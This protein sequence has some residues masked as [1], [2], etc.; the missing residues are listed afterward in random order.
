MDTEFRI[1]A[2]RLG[3]RSGVR[4]GIGPS[5]TV[6]RRCGHRRGRGDATMTAGNS[7]RFPYQACRFLKIRMSKNASSPSKGD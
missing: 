5:E 7:R 3:D 6:V 1:R 4:Q 2:A